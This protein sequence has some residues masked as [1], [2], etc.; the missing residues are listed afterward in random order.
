MT[1]PRLELRLDRIGYN[2]RAL[3]DRL[4]LVGIAVCGV[5]KAT[6]GSPEVAR[7]LCA[8]GTTSLG[9]SRVE[10][11]ERL[12]R[13]GVVAEI[14]LVRSP[15][16]SQVDRVVGCADISCNSDLRVVQHLSAAACRRGMPH[17]IVL[18]VELGDLREGVLPVDLPDLVARVLD[19]P[20][21]VLRG[22]GTNLACQ[23]GVIP[24]QANMA[25]LSDLAT[26]V[27]DLVGHE[28]EIVSGGNSAN[29]PWALAPGADTGR[30]NHLRLGESILL[31]REPVGRTA[32]EGLHTDT[33]SVVAEVIE[34]MRK[35][36]F[37]WGDRGQNAFGH[38]VD[39]PTGSTEA[40]QVIVALGRQDVDTDGL[41]APDGFRI[42]GASSDHLVLICDSAPPQAGAELRFGV[43]YSALM[44][45][46]ASP[47]VSRRY[48][49]SRQEPRAPGG[50]T[51]SAA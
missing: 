23:N 16:V 14:L 41:V 32:L 22:I 21:I 19:L 31:G 39:L 17:G 1:L 28:L 26:A 33:V 30:V 43:D 25:A 5:T 10:N 50:Q 24:D 37:P 49:G 6:T 2:A 7:A 34:S 11:I 18:M 3:V 8:A 44:R 45:A 4:E 9:E 29:L 20:G 46:A 36:T 40:H 35:P 13:S 38:R 12:R 27:E 15:M 42:L 48:R 51:T 47:F